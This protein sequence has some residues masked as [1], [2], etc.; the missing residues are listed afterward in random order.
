MNA[1]DVSRLPSPKLADRTVRRRWTVLVSAVFMLGLAL[2]LMF[3]LTTATDNRALYEA[4]YSRLLAVNILVA[5]V[6]L[7]VIV[8]AL[9]RLIARFRRKKFGSQLLAKI[10]GVF[11]LV[12]LLPGLL[13]YG[14]SY[15]FVSRSIESW[16]DVRVESALTAGVN[17]GRTT[18]DTLAADPRPSPAWWRGSWVRCRITALR[19]SWT[20]CASN[21]PPPMS[22]CGVPRG[23]CWP[24]QVSHGLR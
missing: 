6:L 12:G 10:A 8:W 21:W 17:L 16:F 13:I 19:W 22:S 18:V 3:M 1:R 5:L 2:V 4:N 20:A 7:A 23:S 24:G 15:Q 9:F 14:V 11:A